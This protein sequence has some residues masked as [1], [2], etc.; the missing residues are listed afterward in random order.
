M[1]CEEVI[2]SEDYYDLIISYSSIDMQK[3][4]VLPDC[5]Q[6]I[7]IDYE[8]G[9]YNRQGLPELN[10]S[11]YTYTAIPQCFSL[12]DKSAL[13]SSGI[14]KVQNQPTLSLKGEGIL[15]GF[16]DTGIDYTNPVFQSSE[17]NSRILRIWDQTI[18]NGRKPEGFL[19]GSEYTKEEI[20]TALRSENPHDIVPSVDENGHGTFLAGVAAGSEDIAND[21][22]GAAPYA[23]IAMVKLKPAKQNLRDFYFIPKDAEAYSEGDVMAAIS[24][25]N[26]L[27]MELNK[28]LVL[29]VGLGS[30][31]GSHGGTGPL[32]L[33]LNSIAVI[34]NHVVAIA[35]GNEANSR[36][37]FYGTFDGNETSQ[38]VEIS[39]GDAVKGFTV[40]LWTQAPEVHSV[41]VVSPTGE[42]IARV[43]VRQGNR[44][45]QQFVFEE[46]IV[47]VDYRSVGVTT[48]DWLVFFRFERPTKGLWDV[49][50]YADENIENG[51]YHMWLPLPAFLSGEVFFLRSN[52]DVT[53]TVPATAAV[54]MG[55]GA[56]DAQTGSLFLDSGRG[57]TIS[58]QVK[59]DFVAPGVNVYGPGLRNQYIR[60][61]GTSVA[62]AIAAGGSALLLEWAVMREYDTMVN[63]ADIKNYILRGA[64]RE[65]NIRRYPNREWGYGILDVYESL[66]KLRIR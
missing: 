23:E 1:D 66:N 18:R 25:L 43:P 28:P 38:T 32:S 46:T 40:E 34:R 58:G 44:V 20:D 31:M 54:P 61:T 4:V 17:A 49:V 3:V 6:K 24:Y 47:S 27:S 37:H 52:P 33:Y 8:I 50:V 64:R 26:Q 21:F 7:S 56:Y 30:N 5:R 36:H 57:Y 19:Y 51:R 9:Y 11:D 53:I 10:V 22:I 13:D 65:D 39:V 14:T 35:A 59:P 41:A 16:L 62:A 45:V 2:Y 55:V 42:Q 15:L 48:G 12:M 29:C 63:T 60:M